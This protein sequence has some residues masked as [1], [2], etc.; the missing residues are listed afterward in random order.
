M[1]SARILWMWTISVPRRSVRR[2]R[3]AL[4]RMR[5]ELCATPRPA[6]KRDTTAASGLMGHPDSA[7]SV[8]QEVP[9]RHVSHH[10]RSARPRACRDSSRVPRRGGESFATSPGS[11]GRRLS[12]WSVPCVTIIHRRVPATR[13]YLLNS[14]LRVTRVFDQHPTCSSGF[15]VVQHPLTRQPR[16]SRFAKSYV[17]PPCTLI[18]SQNRKKSST[19]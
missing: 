16:R 10:V 8:S 13:N 12:S 15:A 6:I 4:K 9:A 14:K 5:L 7:T 2:A 18:I 3:P 11:L 17:G 19:C 1:N